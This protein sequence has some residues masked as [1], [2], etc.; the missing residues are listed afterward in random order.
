[1]EMRRYVY[2]LLAAGFGL[3]IASTP[4]LAHHSF[5]AQYDSNKSKTIKGTVTKVEFMNPHIY[6]YVDVM[7][8]GKITNYAVE[9]GT[10]GQLRRRGWGK[11]SLK[12]GDVVTVEGWMAKNGKPNLNGN[13][14]TMADGRRVFAGTSNPEAAREQGEQ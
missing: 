8:D 2:G 11:D 10:P 7:E 4:L 5:A 3:L 1:M 14:V 13:R 6:F 12:A 9:G